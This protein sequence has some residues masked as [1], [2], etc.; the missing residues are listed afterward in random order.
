MLLGTA[1]GLGIGTFLF[2]TLRLGF[3]ASRG[4]FSSSDLSIAIAMALSFTRACIDAVCVTRWGYGYHESDLP[5]D[6]RYSQYLLMLSCITEIIFK[7]TIL[8]TKLSPNHAGLTHVILNLQES[9]VP[10]YPRLLVRS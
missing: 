4:V 5:P 2:V 10:T 8:F 3:R 6:I 1:L 7:L 9:A